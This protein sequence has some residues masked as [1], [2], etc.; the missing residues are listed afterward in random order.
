MAELPGNAKHVERLL[1]ASFRPCVL[2][3]MSVGSGTYVPNR[4]SATLLLV[5]DRKASRFATMCPVRSHQ[6][7]GRLVTSLRPFSVLQLALLRLCRFCLPIRNIPSTSS[8]DP[9]PNCLR[10]TIIDRVLADSFLLDGIHILANSC[11]SKIRFLRPH[12]AGV[13]RAGQHVP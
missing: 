5:C 1:F 11:C 3:P 6:L 12:Q 9:V 13:A 8:V 10:C 4:I 2:N 7:G